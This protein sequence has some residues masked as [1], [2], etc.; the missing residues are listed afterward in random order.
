MF[1]ALIIPF[2]VFYIHMAAI[3][4]DIHFIRH[5]SILNEYLPG[6]SAVGLFLIRIKDKDLIT[7]DSSGDS[8][9]DSADCRPN[10]RRDR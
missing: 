4:C 1:F 6:R 9:N 8:A 10:K 5:F 2:N 7:A 3:H